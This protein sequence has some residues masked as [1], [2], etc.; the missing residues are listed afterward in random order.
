[1]SDI[2]LM[3]CGECCNDGYVPVIVADGVVEYK[4]MSKADCTQCHGTGK[5]KVLASIG[6]R[7]LRKKPGRRKGDP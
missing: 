4:K 3:T 7:H 1:M 6:P 5:V 2:R